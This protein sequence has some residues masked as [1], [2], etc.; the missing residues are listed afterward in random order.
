MTTE[1]VPRPFYW[2][3]LYAQAMLEMDPG[4][5]PSA[6]TRANDAILD[7]I[8]RMDRNSLGHELSA[9][10]DALN[11]LRLLRREYERGMKEYREQ[12]RRRLG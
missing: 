9:L 11:N 6:I 7:R 5:L 1:G 2:K 3:E 12:D 10:N 4:K 8:E